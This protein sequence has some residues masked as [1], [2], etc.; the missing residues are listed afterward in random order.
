METLSSALVRASDA[1]AAQAL[2][3]S[4]NNDQRLNMNAVAEPKYYAAQTASAA[5]IEYSDLAE[6]ITG[7]EGVQQDLAGRRGD[8]CP[9]TLAAALAATSVL[10]SAPPG[11]DIVLPP[12]LSFVVD[13]T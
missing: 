12:T 8:A 4:I 10:T 13:K 5:P 6:D 1:V 9:A 2:M 7:S 11:I 3:N